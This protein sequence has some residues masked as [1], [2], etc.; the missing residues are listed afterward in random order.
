[1]ECVKAYKVGCKDRIREEVECMFSVFKADKCENIEFGKSIAAL[2]KKNLQIW[3]NP[4]N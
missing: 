4:K 3:V 1:M 2:G